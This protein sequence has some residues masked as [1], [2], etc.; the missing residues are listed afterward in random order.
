VRDG[1][2]SAIGEQETRCAEVRLVDSTCL[3]VGVDV[4]GGQRG[5]FRETHAGGDQ[6][7]GELLPPLPLDV[8][9]Q[10]GELG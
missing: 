8:V 1:I 5:G 4:S 2:A 9:S 6:P 7:G 10:E 3:G